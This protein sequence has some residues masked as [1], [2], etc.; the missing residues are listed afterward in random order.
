MGV[1][2]IKLIDMGRPGPLLAV[3]FPRHRVLDCVR[4]G[5]F[6]WAQQA[7]AHACIYPSL[8]LTVDV[9]FLAVWISYRDLPQWLTT[10]WNCKI[11]ESFLPLLPFV[12]IFYHSNR[13]SSRAVREKEMDR[14]PCHL[15]DGPAD[16][17]PNNSS[18]VPFYCTPQVWSLHQ[19]SG[20]PSSVERCVIV[21]WVGNVPHKLMC[22]SS[23]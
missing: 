19:V 21:L 22:L 5:K 17:R 20:I 15:G 14:W 7:G 6:S 10:T 13:N 18:C 3:P 16:F 11:R 12:R 9:L 2:L 1:V 23:W 4:V 8:F